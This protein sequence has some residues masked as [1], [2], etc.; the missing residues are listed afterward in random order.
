MSSRLEIIAC[1]KTVITLIQKLREAQMVI[2]LVSKVISKFT[3]TE[4]WTSMYLFGGIHQNIKR[5]IPKKNSKA[6]EKNHR[7]LD[8]YTHL[9]SHPKK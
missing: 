9:P 5:P 4:S 7:I 1:N 3:H 6:K 2:F 8:N